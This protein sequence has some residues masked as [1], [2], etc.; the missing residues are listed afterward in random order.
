MAGFKSPTKEIDEPINWFRR[1][2]DIPGIRFAPSQSFDRTK[3]RGYNIVPKVHVYEFEGKRRQSLAWP[4]KNG[5]ASAS[6]A[7]QHAIVELGNL[8]SAKLL[9]NMYECIELPGRPSDYHFLIQSRAEELWKR[10][11]EEPSV[12][13]EVE[14][15]CWLDIR[16]IETR[17][18]IIRDEY[19]EEPNFYRVVAFAT[20]ID[21]Y[22]REGFLREALGVSD[23]AAAF[24]QGEQHQQRLRARIAAVEAEDAGSPC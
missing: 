14:K 12:L 18:D 11:R 24:Q 2:G 7:Q 21:L 8:P 5:E 15:L 23:R 13:E 22:E 6:P 16:L 9:R 4:I 10:R 1:L 17:P 20:L 3:L 19:T